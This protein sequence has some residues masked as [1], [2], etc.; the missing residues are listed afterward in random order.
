MKFDLIPVMMQL[1]RPETIINILVPCIRI[2]GNASTTHS[3]SGQIIRN[4]GFD[5]LFNLLE[6]QNKVVRR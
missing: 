1:M 2:C 4:N 3:A 5:V 6:H